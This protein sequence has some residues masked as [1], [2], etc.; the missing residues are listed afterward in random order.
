MIW[1]IFTEIQLGFLNTILFENVEYLWYFFF[2]KDHNHH[3]RD[4]V[5]DFTLRLSVTLVWVI[6]TVANFYDA[7]SM[8]WRISKST[9]ISS[10]IYLWPNTKF[11]PL[12]CV[13]QLFWDRFLNKWVLTW[14]F[15]IS[16]MLHHKK[17]EMV[18]I[19]PT[20]YGSK[21]GSSFCISWFLP[22]SKYPIIIP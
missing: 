13:S 11:S 12:S 3:L 18:N 2:G 7:T 6:L 22:F 5:I 17:L 8:Q 16:L 20:I 10:V 14:K 9:L 15:V 4:C 21:I 1:L 19:M